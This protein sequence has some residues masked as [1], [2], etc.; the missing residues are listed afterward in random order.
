MCAVPQGRREIIATNCILQYQKLIH[1]QVVFIR[2]QTYDGL[3]AF[4]EFTEGIEDILA[5]GSV[6]V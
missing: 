4:A 6:L 3:I 5:K 2:G 1:D